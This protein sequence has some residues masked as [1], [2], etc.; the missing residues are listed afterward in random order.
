MNSTTK[1]AKRYPMNGP[2]MAEQADACYFWR[3]MR[4]AREAIAKMRK[5]RA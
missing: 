3:S 4:A 5:A 2:S 1:S